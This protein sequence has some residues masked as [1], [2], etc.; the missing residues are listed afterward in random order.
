MPVRAPSPADAELLEGAV[1]VHVHGGPDVIPR[2]HSDIELARRARAAGMAAI[3]IKCHSE[4]TVGRAA[5]AAEATGFRVAGGIVL[6]PA[7]A[8]GIDPDVVRNSLDLGARVVWMPTL[9]ATGH[10]RAFP[11]VSPGANRAAPR[12]ARVKRAA[13]RAICAHVARADA[14][15]ATG[16]LGRAHA[17][18]VAEEAT[19]V[20]ARVLFQHP[21]Y[22]VPALGLR[23]Q[24]A[25][26]ERF[27]H[28]LF[29]RCAFVVSPGA[30]HPTTIERVAAAIRAV[31]PG[32]NVIS[33]DLGQP[34]NGDY[35]DR[36]ARFARDLIGEGFTVDELR[37][38]LVERPAAL[39]G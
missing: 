10:L 8:G 37:T 30:P 18:V 19:A 11:G 24:A 29:E 12:P 7:V 21:D 15:I 17:T 13:I 1:D 36:L 31:G 32:R 28:A 26:A 22:T 38:M 3:V 27:P 35:P 4:S 16:H 9:A 20:G 14:F 25:L 39:L 2:R 5:G 6:N 34:A 33:S 23:T